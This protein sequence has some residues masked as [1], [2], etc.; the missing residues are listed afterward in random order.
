MAASSGAASLE[1]AQQPDASV[2]YLAGADVA[3]QVFA[4]GRGH[5]FSRG[6]AAHSP[7]LSFRPEQAGL[8]E[9]TTDIH[10]SGSVFIGTLLI[11][12]VPSLPEVRG[13]S[14]H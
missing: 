1:A 5:G 3:G 13:S 4:D 11:A 10:I 12:Y 9:P 8:L 7:Q 14:T 2:R 6:T